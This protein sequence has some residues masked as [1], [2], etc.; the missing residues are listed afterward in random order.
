MTLALSCQ[1]GRKNSVIYFHFEQLSVILV[2]SLLLTFNKYAASGVLSF[3]VLHFYALKYN[4]ENDERFN[5]REYSLFFL[6][7]IFL[8]PNIL[9][10]Q[11]CKTFTKLAP[12]QNLSRISHRRCSVKKIFLKF[13]K[14]HG[15]ASVLES[16]LNFIKKRPQHRCLPV[17]FMNIL[18]TSILKNICERL[19]LTKLNRKVNLWL[20]WYIVFCIIT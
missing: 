8:I 9:K 20:S 3:S 1:Y 19:L 15:K 6:M 10:W 16:V 4:K 14:F 2:V 5:H 7:G 13:T 18:I 11:K 12:S 17:K